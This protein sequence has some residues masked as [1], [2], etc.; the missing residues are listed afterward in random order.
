MA[1]HPL[2]RFLVTAVFCLSL[3]GMPSA[4]RSPEPRALP[5]FTQTLFF[6][7]FDQGREYPRHRP[8]RTKEG[9]GIDPT[10]GAPK[11]P[12]SGGVCP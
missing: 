1:S 6:W 12:C 7:V 4:P 5:S 2:S 10:G 9:I 11:P 8:I 3:L